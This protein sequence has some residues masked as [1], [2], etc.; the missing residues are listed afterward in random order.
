[1]VKQRNLVH[2]TK[3]PA[4][5]DAFYKNIDQDGFIDSLKVG[6]Q[7]KDRIKSIVPRKLV[8]FLKKYF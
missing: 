6:L 7:L 1:M 2:P 8:F 5:R 4:E 3:R